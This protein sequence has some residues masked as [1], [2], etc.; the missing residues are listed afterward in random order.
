MIENPASKLRHNLV[1]KLSFP[2]LFLRTLS[3]SDRADFYGLNHTDSAIQSILQI[4]SPIIVAL[5]H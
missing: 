5:S 2:I 1:L 4:A 3:P